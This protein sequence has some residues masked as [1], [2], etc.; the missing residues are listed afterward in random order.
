LNPKSMVLAH[1]PDPLHA[2]TASRERTAFA[3]VSLALMAALYAGLSIF[4]FYEDFFKYIEPGYSHFM[5]DRSGLAVHVHGYTWTVLSPFRVAMAAGTVFLLGFAAISLLRGYR[6]G[7]PLALFTLWGVLLPQAFWYTEFVVDWHQ[8]H[9][10]TAV[11]AI[12][13]MAA[14]LPTALLYE[15]RQ[16]LA[17]WSSRC[18]APS[19]I[20]GAAIALGWLGFLATECIDHSYQL[21]SDA[22]YAGALIAIGL[23]ALGAYGL[24]RLRAWALPAA[25]GAC[26]GFA[27]IPLAFL[28]SRYLPSG[29]YIDA[30]VTGTTGT[31]WAALFTAILPAA[32][33]YVIAGPYLRAF[34]RRLTR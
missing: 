6:G 11:I 27:V 23:S 29:G 28:S 7:R 22:A 16:T 33:L 9:G 19:R 25:L 1:H 4:Y 26:A 24:L 5:T 17:G 30:A 14:A 34:F 13:L 8:G 31:A 21:R 10:L 2:A 3:A 12:A 20:V 32:V 15:G 18:A